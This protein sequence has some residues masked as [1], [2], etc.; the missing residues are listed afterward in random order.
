[1]EVS[2][3]TK[4]GAMVDAVAVAAVD[5]A[6]KIRGNMRDHDDLQTTEDER[7]CHFKMP[8]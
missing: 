2:S 5:V 4:S 1:M 6:T 3:H 7:R 8:M